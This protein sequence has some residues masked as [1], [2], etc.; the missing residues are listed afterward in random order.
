[1]PSRA[2]RHRRGSFRRRIAELRERMRKID[3]Q[4]RMEWLKRVRDS[5]IR[6][7]DISRERS[8]SA[9]VELKV[10][11]VRIDSAHRI[12]KEVR[13]TAWSTELPNVQVQKPDFRLIEHRTCRTSKVSY[14]NL[15]HALAYTADR[16]RGIYLAVQ[17]IV[18]R[19][20]RKLVISTNIYRADAPKNTK[21]ALMV[22]VAMLIKWGVRFFTTVMKVAQSIKD[23]NQKVRIEFWSGYY[24]EMPVFLYAFTGWIAERIRAV[25]L[26]FRE[27]L[28]RRLV[29]HCS[30]YASIAGL[31][32]NGM[33]S[34]WRIWKKRWRICGNY[35]STYTHWGKDVCYQICEDLMHSIEPDRLEF[36]LNYL[37]DYINKYMQR[38]GLYVPPPITYNTTVTGYAIVE[39]KVDI[40]G[41]IVIDGFLDDGT[42]LLFAQTI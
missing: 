10:R 17:N 6:R 32:Y 42:P 41:R 35:C 29:R 9:G 19:K 40:W 25:T 15:K 4:R 21:Q 1:M 16:I 28:L 14:I 34:G 38:L 11:N 24:I 5:I 39:N 20:Y 2:W 36:A 12:E 13:K 33:V 31:R 7:A 27:L 23:W 30:A 26:G 3:L 37:P 18:N 8:R 22:F